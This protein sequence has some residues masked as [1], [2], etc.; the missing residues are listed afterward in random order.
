M[1]VTDLS[2]FQKR[3]DSYTPTYILTYYYSFVLYIHDSYTLTMEIGS[4]A[5]SEAHH[6]LHATPHLIISQKRPPHH[7]PSHNN[8]GTAPP[9]TSLTTMTNA[10]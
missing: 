6:F 1:G 4:C 3:Q 5:E 8:S 10:D 9:P 7:T 2:V